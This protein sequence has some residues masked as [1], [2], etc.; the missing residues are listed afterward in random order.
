MA[1]N[2]G[3]T[4]DILRRSVIG[5]YTSAHALGKIDASTF[6]INEHLGSL[7]QADYP[8]HPYWKNYT[9]G[10][11]QPEGFTVPAGRIV[12]YD[13]RSQY[14]GSAAQENPVGIASCYQAFSKQSM[15]VCSSFNLV[16]LSSYCK[17]RRIEGSTS[18]DTVFKKINGSTRVYLQEHHYVRY[19]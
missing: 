16:D 18:A 2:Q 11:V 10:D 17:H 13:L 9:H 7:P 3:L 5:G 8:S 15:P 1:E 19:K 14:A 4:N 12:T 6:V